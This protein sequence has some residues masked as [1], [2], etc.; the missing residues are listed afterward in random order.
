MQAVHPTN[1]PLTL[2]WGRLE[3]SSVNG[4]EYLPFDMVVFFRAA[5]SY[6]EVHCE[7]GMRTLVSGNIGRMERSLPSDQFFRCHRSYLVNLYHVLR[8]D[9]VDGYGALLKSEL[10]IPVG[11]RRWS[12]LRRAMLATALHG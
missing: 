2:R 1:A 9:R 4:V 6:T 12:L 3:I 5:G 10:R 11:K 7:N 8:L